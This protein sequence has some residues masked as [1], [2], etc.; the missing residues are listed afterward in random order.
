[1]VPQKL[2]DRAS[3]AFIVWDAMKAITAMFEMRVSG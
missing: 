2:A 3:I 1:M